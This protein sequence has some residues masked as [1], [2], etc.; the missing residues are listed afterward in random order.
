MLPAGETVAFASLLAPAA[1][2][3]A[4]RILA[5]TS[6]GTLTLFAFG[7]GQQLNEHTAPVD[8]IVTVLEGVL[9]VTVGGS[10]LQAAAGSVVRLPAGVPHAVRA[11]APARMLL[12]LLRDITAA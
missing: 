8:A 11:A 9:D 3:I 1:G 4:S 2:S 5:R 12:L 10:P 6:G 7:A